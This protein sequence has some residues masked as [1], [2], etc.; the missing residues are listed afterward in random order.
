MVKIK[1]INIQ[2]S[3]TPNIINS[4]NFT[5]STKPLTNKTDKYSLYSINSTLSS[6][7]ETLETKMQCI[8]PLYNQSCLFKNLYYVDS[9]F[10]ILLVKGSYLPEYYL[11]TDAFNLWPITPNKREFDSYI[12]LEIFVRNITKPRRIPYVTLYFGQPWHHN[13]GHALFDGLYAAYVALIRFSPRHLYPFHILAG[14]DDCDGCWSEDVYSRFGGLGIIKQRVLNKLSQGRWFIFDEIIMGSGTF[15]QRCTQSNLQLPGGVELNASRLFRDR[16]YQ[17]HGFIHSV[18]RQKSSSEYR[19]S[20]DLLHAYVIDNRRFTENDR[21]EIKD[22]INEINNYTNF[23]IN[24][25]KSNTSKSEWPLIQISYL[26]YNQVKAQNMSSIQINA[27]SSDSRSPTYELIE[28]DFIAQLKIL[29]KM[30]IHITGPGT[31][32]MYQTFL[33]DG[34]VSINL[35]GLRPWG[36]E[37]T[38]KGYASYLEQHMTSGTP[39]IKGLYYPINERTKGI[40]K[41]EVIKLVRQAG[42]LILQGFSLPVQPRENLAADG[43]LFV[44]M[45]EKDKEFCASVT[46]RSPHKRFICL[47]FWVEDFVHE[48]NQWKEGGYIDNGHND[49]CSFNRSLLRQLREKYGIKHNLENSSKPL[50]I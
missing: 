20:H 44:E 1:N 47:E 6:S 41:D 36:L 16:M 34:S 50:Q 40:K 32:Q 42:Q 3:F 10:T 29:R 28:N 7:D 14:V 15:C 45:C 31:G 12:H 30:D 13:I 5:I 37:N 48:Y 25:S 22:A 43:Q 35:G 11:R 2:T 9:W 49:G 39:Y 26:Y 4:P 17:Q 18:V 33:S 19:T 21:K 24:T 8:G 46:T 38:P 23:Y 27:T